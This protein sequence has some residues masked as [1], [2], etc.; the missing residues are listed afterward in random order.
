MKH[1][2]INSH[3]NYLDH[4]IKGAPAYTSF[5]PSSFMWGNRGPDSVVHDLFK[6]T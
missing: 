2:I 3:W 5:N 4:K 1:T 6:A